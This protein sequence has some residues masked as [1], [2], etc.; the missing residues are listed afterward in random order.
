MLELVVGARPRDLGGATVRRVLPS[1]RRRLVGPFAFL[2]HMGPL[3]L[4]PGQGFD[5]AP[6]P[7]IGLATVTYLYEGEIVH[8]DSLGTEQTIRPGDVNWMTAGRGIVHSERSTP[9][10]RQAGPRVHGVQIWVALPD[11]REDGAPGFQHVPA[12]DLPRFRAGQ[13][14]LVLVAGAAWG[15]TSPV[16]VESPLFQADARLP[17]GAELELPEAAERAAYVVEGAVEHAGEHGPGALLVFGPGGAA[18]R[19]RAPSRLVLFGGA[20]VGERHYLWNFVSSSRARLEQAAA[21]WRAGRFPRVPGDEVDFV[22]M[23]AG[24]R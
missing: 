15:R 23:P 16:A 22:P 11:G 5:V 21:D 3:A 9:A 8:R 7:H 12:A 19:A 10:A 18:L 20:P 17:A 24:L 4:P 2:D 13:A 6:H 1:M 14:D